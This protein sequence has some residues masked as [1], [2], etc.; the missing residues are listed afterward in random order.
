MSEIDFGLLAEIPTQ[1]LQDIMDAIKDGATE[2]GDAMGFGP[3][4]LNAIEDM[5]LA[6]YRG[7]QYDKASTLYGFVLRMNA[8]R[9]SAWR[10]LGACSHAL[11]VYFIAAKC[12]EMAV[13]H[14]PSD[15]IS[16]VYLGECLCQI[17][18]K[19]A[20]LKLLGEAVETGTK[21]ANLLPFISRARMIVSADGGLP[22]RL[23]LMEHGK[24]ILSQGTE[25][26]AADSDRE[27][28]ADDILANPQNKA[29]IDKLA[30]MVKDNRLTYAEIGGFTDKELDGAYACACKYAEIGKLGEAMQIVGFLMLLDPH[31]G[32]YYQLGG[33]CFQLLK[34][35]EHAECYYDVAL[36]YDPD[37]AMS[38]VYR[39]ESL[40]MLVEI[41]AGVTFVKEGVEKA[42]TKEFADVK[43]RGQALIQQFST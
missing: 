38:L 11:K 17:G 29:V 36:A 7:Q 1:D 8:T 31:K 26:V 4:A 37:N 25:L 5:A 41:D 23:V 39:G 33:V 21:D 35:Y 15:L 22:P 19:T 13:K 24:T 6:H 18:E 9:A 12:Y 10:G 30:E 42:T 40:I 27:I 14:D 32:R 34:Q 28:T 16:K 43:K 3:P 20:G 2:P